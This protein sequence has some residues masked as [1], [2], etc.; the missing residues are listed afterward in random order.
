MLAR[1]RGKRATVPQILGLR[2]GELS[3]QLGDERRQVA[4]LAEPSEALKGGDLV[5][6]KPFVDGRQRK[7]PGRRPDGVRELVERRRFA[8]L[9]A[10]MMKTP[11]DTRNRAGAGTLPRLSVPLPG[12][13]G[14]W[15]CRRLRLPVPPDSRRRSAANH[16]RGTQM[17]V[18]MR[19]L[20]EAGVH[21][22]HQTRRWNPK[23]RRFIFG[24]RGGIYII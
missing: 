7:L 10:P 4:E 15:G 3:R 11:A 21:F 6:G 13:P 24:E 23:M 19:E 12:D 9:H 22:G 14:R 17:A 20:L 1:P 18:S 16:Q 5:A 2:L 8:C